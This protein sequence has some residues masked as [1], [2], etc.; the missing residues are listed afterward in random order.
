MLGLSISNAAAPSARKRAF[1]QHIP[2]TSCPIRGKPS[3]SPPVVHKNGHS[4]KSGGQVA[5]TGSVHEAN[6]MM[7]LVRCRGALLLVGGVAFADPDFNNGMLWL[8]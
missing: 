2:Q 5:G 3:K 6:A 7:S 1:R 8:H 4:V